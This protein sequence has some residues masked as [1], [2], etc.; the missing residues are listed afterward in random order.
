M[1][2][3]APPVVL[4]WCQAIFLLGPIKEALGE[5]RFRADGEI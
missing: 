2:C 3:H 5:K 4:A 1:Y